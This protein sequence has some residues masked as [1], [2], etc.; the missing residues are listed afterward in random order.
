[1]EYKLFNTLDVP[2]VVAMAVLWTAHTELFFTSWMELCLSVV[3]TC[4]SWFYL[5]MALELEHRTVQ[6]QPYVV[7]AYM[8]S[9]FQIISWCDPEDGICA[10]C[11]G[12]YTALYYILI[13]HVF[14]Q[15]S[16]TFSS[17]VVYTKR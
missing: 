8:C 5:K 6:E 17:W 15:F 16:Q 2:R 10:I 1:M 13:L 11:L 14:M 4:S 3:L 12:Y 7:A 9:N